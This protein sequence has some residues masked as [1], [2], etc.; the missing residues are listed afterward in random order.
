VHV[1]EYV[2]AD[3]ATGEFSAIYARSW[4]NVTGNETTFSMAFIFE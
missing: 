1:W 4:E 2:A 3:E